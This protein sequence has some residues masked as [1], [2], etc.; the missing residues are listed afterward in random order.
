MRPPWQACG[1]VMDY[2]RS[3]YRSVVRPYAGRPD[4]E[5][6][7]CWRWCPP[8]APHLPYPHAFGS[9]NWDEFHVGISPPVG[10]IEPR[11]GWVGGGHGEGVSG[12]Y[13]GTAEDWAGAPYDP[14]RVGVVWPGCQPPPCGAPGGPWGVCESVPAT[15][16]AVV[17]VDFGA[18]V[19][20]IPMEWQPGVLWPAFAGPG[21]YYG[22]L[23]VVCG[24]PYLVR[25]VCPGGDLLTAASWRFLPPEG[26]FSTGGSLAY[27]CQ[28][29]DAVDAIGAFADLGGT[30]GSHFFTIALG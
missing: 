17:T 8:G 25:L 11:G 29:F 4:I 14:S 6:A 27:V 12:V 2:L 23:A 28:P 3:C 26:G 15:A 5:V 1:A 13:R 21:V 19:W 16:V 7:G 9:R 22:E 30:C 20:A 10:E 18:A 24:G